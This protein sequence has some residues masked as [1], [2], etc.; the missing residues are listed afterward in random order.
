MTDTYTAAIDKLD[1]LMDAIEAQLGTL[2]DGSIVDAA[3]LRGACAGHLATA[4]EATAALEALVGLGV[5]TPQSRGY[6][7]DR[8]RWAATTLYRLGVRHGLGR[9]AVARDQVQL[10]AALPQGLAQRVEEAIRSSTVDLRGAIVDLVAA[11]HHDLVLASPF[12]DAATLE[13][14]RPAVE[15]R[16]A[17]GVRVRIL[18]RF[19]DGL[20]NS[21]RKV[22]VH[23]SGY[24]GCRFLS[25]YEPT[26]D[27]PFGARTFHFKAAIADAGARAYLGTA[28]FTASGLRS[29]L[30]I[31][32][33][34]VGQPAQQL[35]ALV[36]AV[37]ALAHPVSLGTHK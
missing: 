29:R 20:E 5:L 37:L 25:W 23:L 11:T 17:M 7:F 26:V 27:D 2:T 3:S 24:P 22:M 16:L 33:L 21:V 4:D 30:E 14:I 18:G 35:A 15:R 1:W 28:N 6:M 31:G 12:W 19:G 9:R 36:D 8:E 13:E 34:L 10:C 32:V